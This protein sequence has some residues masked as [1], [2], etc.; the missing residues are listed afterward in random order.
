MIPASDPQTGALPAG[1]HEATWAEVVARFG[2][3]AQRDRLLDGMKKALRWVAQAGGT[4]VYLGGSFV[5]AKAEP[6]DWDGCVQAEAV[7]VDQL[8]DAIRG[9]NTW[10]MKQL[11]A[12]ELFIDEEEN[13][14]ISYF[15]RNKRRQ[16]V[17]IIA[18]T[19]REEDLA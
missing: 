15:Q 17:G 2:G 10:V 9:E 6:G 18:L 16:P 11:Y 5:T 4:R 13:D 19:L 7:N 1:I 12:G 14:F 3:T 8:S